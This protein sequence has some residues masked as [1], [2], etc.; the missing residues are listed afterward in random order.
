MKNEVN[1]ESGLRMQ[2]GVN[3][4]VKLPVGWSRKTK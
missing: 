3:I 1:V 4:E 2:N